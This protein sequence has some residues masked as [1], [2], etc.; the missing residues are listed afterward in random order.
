MK[1]IIS[2]MHFILLNNIYLY[3]YMVDNLTLPVFKKMGGII[4]N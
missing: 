3:S 1:F 2:I 4:E